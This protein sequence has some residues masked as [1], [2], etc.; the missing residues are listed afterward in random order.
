MRSSLRFS[1]FSA[2]RFNPQRPQRRAK[3]LD[4]FTCVFDLSILM[5]ELLKLQPPMSTVTAPGGITTPPDAVGSAILAAG[6]PPI[7]TV[8]DPM[9]M[10][11]T[12]HVSPSRAAGKPIISTVGA[13]GG[14]IG[15]GT[16]SVAVLTIKSVTLAAGSIFSSTP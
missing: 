6:I 9:M 3:M 5:V 15:V 13:P 4:K 16:P 2:V 10:A 8:A 11:S 1:A 12:P 14:M 7:R